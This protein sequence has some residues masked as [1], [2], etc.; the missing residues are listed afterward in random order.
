MLENA[1]RT[2]QSGARC[3]SPFV[4]LF[5]NRP[6]SENARIASKVACTS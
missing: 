3:V 2:R 4:S 6:Q 5:Y 1:T